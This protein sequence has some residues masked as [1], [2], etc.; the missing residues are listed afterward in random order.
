MW[1]W[2]VKTGGNLWRTTGDIRDE[3][4]SM[5]RIG[6]SQIAIAPYAHPGQWNDPDMLEVGNGGMNTE[7]Y[8][9]H[10]SLW[11]LL[12]A[13]LMAGNDLRSMSDD[14]KSILMN[15]DVIAIDQ[16]TAVKPVQML[17]EQGKVEILEGP[18]RMGRWRSGSLIVATLPPTAPCPGKA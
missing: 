8:R 4:G 13:P 10:M 17:A 3:W 16:D 5:E 15:A 12:A 14:T 6:F 18:C 2:G 7:E 1:K 11:A 9:T